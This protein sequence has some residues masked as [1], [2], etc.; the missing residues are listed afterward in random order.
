MSEPALAVE[1]VS[2]RYLVRHQLSQNREGRHKT[3]REVIT[4]EVRSLARNAIN[5]LSGK[6]VVQGDEVEEFWALK[7]VNFE[8]GQGEAV[9]IIGRSGAG[10]RCSRSNRLS[11]GTH[12]PREHLP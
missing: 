1:K 5:V 9:G 4:D 10:K 8:I 6:P 7:N 12:R 3:F 2:K 11:S